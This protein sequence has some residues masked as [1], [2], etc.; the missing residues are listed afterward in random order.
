VAEVRFAGAHTGGRRIDGSGRSVNLQPSRSARGNTRVTSPSPRASQ[1]EATTAAGRIRHWWQGLTVQGVVWRRFV[2]W[3]VCNVPDWLHPALVWLGSFVFF[4]FAAPARKTLLQN[5]R[6]IL[7][8]SSRPANYLRVIRIFSNF[9]WTLAEA[10]LYRLRN[11]RFDY[12]LAGETY[13]RQLAAAPGAIALTAH[14]GNYDLGA[15][16]FAEK[17]ERRLRMVRAPEPDALSGQ[18]VDR[19]LQQASAGAVKVDYSTD[20][21]SVALDLLNALR[22]GEIISIQ[23]DRVIGDVAVSAVTLFGHKASLPSGPFILSFVTGTPIYPLFIVRAGYRKYKIIA[24][25]PITCS[26]H[27]RTREEAIG[28]AMQNWAQILEEQVRRH[29]NQ[30]YAF[31]PVFAG[32]ND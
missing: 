8:G 11:P 5:L 27:N 2:D 4:F 25:A 29:W 20:G 30:W 17:F 26:G 23:G 3:A 12:E 24:C 1:S 10:A 21:A 32:V 16:L 6:I 9:G 19:S 14:M 28:I 7:P 18:H 15:A 31:T 13:L 22:N